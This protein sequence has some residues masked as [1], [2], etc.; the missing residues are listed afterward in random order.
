MQRASIAALALAGL[1]SF[2]GGANAQ[3]PLDP[4][5]FCGK[6]S[7][8][9]F[10]NGVLTTQD[11][12]TKSLDVVRRA[13]RVSLP[14]EEFDLLNFESDAVYNPTNGPLLDLLEA[15]LQD[16]ATDTRE[17][18]LILARIVPAPLGFEDIITDIIS[19]AAL[20]A[21]PIQE[22]HVE[23]YRSSIRQG[24]KVI[25][26]AHSQGNFFGNLS[27]DALTPDER[28]SFG[29]VSAA[30]PDSFVAGGGPHTTLH[31]DFV[32]EAI[33]AAKFLAL[34]PRPQASNF[35][36]GVNTDPL[37]HSFLDAYMEGP[38]S[39]ARI[40]GHVL[41]T[42]DGLVQPGEEEEDG[43]ITV[44]AGLGSAVRA[45]FFEPPLSP[46]GSPV[47][48][49]AGSSVSVACEDLREGNYA[50]QMILNGIPEPLPRVVYVIEAGDKVASGIYQFG[51][52]DIFPPD[53]P[54][55]PAFDV[56]V[57]GNQEDGFR[58]EVLSAPN[59]P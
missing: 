22:N 43:V 42:L 55:G 30:N 21:S 6:R 44:F 46:G 19:A 27:Y 53:A 23:F 18:W 51:E 10:G 4:Q 39:R 40:I 2:G 58:F 38:G 20:A 13:I 48:T 24:K 31:E 36:N 17:Y 49:P 16:I 3:Q 14:P 29:I 28:Q 45:I 5:L 35:T 8:V 1:I 37:G 9:V 26:V 50:Y 57:T 33:D 52:G 59:T 47:E 12:A 15:Y 34:Q 32:I 56:E 25:L 7:V 41:G 11:S 54:D